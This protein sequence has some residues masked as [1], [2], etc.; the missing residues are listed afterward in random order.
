MQVTGANLMNIR[1]KAYVSILSQDSG[2]EI[3][4]IIE[5]AK[6]P[7]RGQ[8]ALG[9]EPFSQKFCEEVAQAIEKINPAPTRKFPSWMGGK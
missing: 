3:S 2:L 6:G 7:L 8:I 5:N 9:P 4:G 1:A